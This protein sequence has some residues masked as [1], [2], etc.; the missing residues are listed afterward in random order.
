MSLSLQTSVCKETTHK[1]CINSLNMFGILN[2]FAFI[3]F[4]VDRLSCELDSWLLLTYEN[5]RFCVVQS[6]IMLSAFILSF[7]ALLVQ[8]I[9]SVYYI[10]AI[11]VAKSSFQF[12][13]WLPPFSKYIPK[14]GFLWFQSQRTKLR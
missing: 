7:C 13:N 1:S 11:V 6:I 9:C 5:G 8:Y 14:P 2:V 12:Y 10:V 4:I 3:I